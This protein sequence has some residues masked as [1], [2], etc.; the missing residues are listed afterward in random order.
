MGKVRGNFIVWRKNI[1]SL[2][3]S[4][5]QPIRPSIKSRVKIKMLR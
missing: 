3:C 5:A 1:V 4:Q 2:E